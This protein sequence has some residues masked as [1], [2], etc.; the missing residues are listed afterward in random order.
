[1]VYFID[2]I[3]LR[4]SVLGG[5]YVYIITHICLVVYWHS[6]QLLGVL[7]VQFSTRLRAMMDERD[8]TIYKVAKDI[9]VSDS[10]VGY[11]VRGKR[12]PALDNLVK[13]ADY[14]GITLDDLV[15]RVPPEGE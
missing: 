15:G 14:F 1:M 12:Q 9:E 10:L 7:F 6:S 2:I 11:W 5:L 13:L 4:L 3:S 8:L